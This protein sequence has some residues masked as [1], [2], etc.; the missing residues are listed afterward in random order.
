MASN[1]ETGEGG[2]SVVCYLTRQIQ[3][4]EKQNVE[5]ALFSSS[6]LSIFLI[7]ELS[8]YERWENFHPCR[9]EWHTNVGV[10]QFWTINAQ[11]LVTDEKLLALVPVLLQAWEPDGED[12][13]WHGLYVCIRRDDRVLTHSLRYFGVTSHRREASVFVISPKLSARVSF[14][15]FW[16]VRVRGQREVRVV[17]AKRWPGDGSGVCRP[18]ED[19]VVVCQTLLHE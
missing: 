19:S 3:V 10:L 13:A 7:H 6:Q 14:L 9:Q 12:D 4:P 8:A 15:S 2:M 16:L 5:L 17:P 1:E 11:L 18:C